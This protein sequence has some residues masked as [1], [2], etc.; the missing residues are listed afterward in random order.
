MG[1]RLYT[2]ADKKYRREYY[3][4]NKEKQNAQSAAWRAN[5]KE[6]KQQ[7]GVEW[8]RRNHERSLANARRWKQENRDALRRYKEQY[9]SDPENR[10]K[11]T[12]ST[13]VWQQ[14]NRGKK[15]AHERNRRALKSRAEGRPTFDEIMSL[16][17]IQSGKCIFFSVCGN[18]LAKDRRTGWHVD[19]VEPL[20]PKDKSRTP[21]NNQINN[22][23]ILCG[24]CNMQKK[25]RDPYEFAQQN[26]LLFCDIVDIAKRLK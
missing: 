15:A 18:Y 9:R 10:K 19:H 20:R 11:E 24:Q 16:W 12:A 17:E 6:K 26:G 21:G 14:K 23:Q 22:L 25:N 3:L 2:E 5:N 1:K 4:R 13:R 7:D 8:H